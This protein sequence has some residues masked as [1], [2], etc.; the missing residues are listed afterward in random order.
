MAK[1]TFPV[2][3]PAT[4]CVVLALGA[5]EAVAKAKLDCPEH[6]RMEEKAYGKGVEAYCTL[7]DGS[8]H[9]PWGGWFASNQ[10]AITG[11]YENGKRHGVETEWYD[12]ETL[13]KRRG[14]RRLLFGAP[15]RYRKHWSAGKLHGESVE[16]DID[17]RVLEKSTWHGGEFVSYDHA[18]PS[19]LADDARLG[20]PFATPRK[21]RGCFAHE[22]F[23]SSLR[24]MMGEP[25]EGY[26]GYE[27]LYGTNKDC[28]RDDKPCRNFSHAQ[29][30]YLMGQEIGGYTESARFA[31]TSCQT[32]ADQRR[33]TAAEESTWRAQSA[34]GRDPG[35]LALLADMHGVWCGRATRVQQGMEFY[36]E[37]RI[38]FIEDDEERAAIA[39]DTWSRTPSGPVGEPGYVMTS[40]LIPMPRRGVDITAVAGSEASKPARQMRFKAVSV[41]KNVGGYS[42]TT[43]PEGEGYVL[44]RGRESYP[45]SQQCDGFWSPPSSDTSD[46][47]NTPGR[48]TAPG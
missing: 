36:R 22:Y 21:P 2:T 26:S 6:T 25:A 20:R 28:Q 41:H 17:G 16:W 14:L 18:K 23:P 38:E 24:T 42:L 12:R 43:G 30:S 39:T 5:G 3:L 40:L 32:R 44:Q 7:G 29:L 10:R 27:I 11:F 48:D 8:R 1:F 47:L 33:A 35:V 13:P 45:L 15:K 9:G 4:L 37:V 34:V 31:V 46:Y 19:E